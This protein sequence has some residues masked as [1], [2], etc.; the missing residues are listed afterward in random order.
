MADSKLHDVIMIGAG[1]AALSAAIYTTREDIDTVLF[2]KRGGGRL[3]C[4][5]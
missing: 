5:Y 1:P 3:G 4:D 2:R